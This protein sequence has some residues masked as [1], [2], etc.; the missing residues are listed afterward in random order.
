[1]KQEKSVGAVIY[2]KQNDT[3]YVLLVKHTA[4]TLPSLYASH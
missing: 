1:M 3:M 4:S 2:Q